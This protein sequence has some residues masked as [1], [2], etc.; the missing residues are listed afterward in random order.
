[1]PSRPNKVAVT[2]VG[3]AII[4]MNRFEH[5]TTVYVEATGT[6]T[7]TLQWTLANLQRG[8]TPVWADFP[9]GAVGGTD[10][11]GSTT[12]SFPVMA[13]KLEVTSGAG[14]AEAT[15]IQAP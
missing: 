14:T 6:V 7:W 4:P 13:L 11:D 8:E 10:A 15:I 1:M 9:T 3:S 2:G 12:F 5:Y